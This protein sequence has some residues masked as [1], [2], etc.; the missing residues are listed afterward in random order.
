V[1]VAALTE[2]IRAFM[3]IM[4]RPHVGKGL[5]QSGIRQVVTSHEHDADAYRLRFG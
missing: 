1:R 5:Y 3:N 2:Y 4:Y